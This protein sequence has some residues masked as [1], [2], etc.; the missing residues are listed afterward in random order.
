MDTQK[1]DQTPAGNDPIIVKNRPA[2]GLMERELTVCGSRTTLRLEPAIWASLEDMAG[3]DEHAIDDLC[4]AISMSRPTEGNLS[5]SIRQ[6]VLGF[7]RRS[8]NLTVVHSRHS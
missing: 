6:F 3:A 2:D 4:T 5:N 1:P 8:P 7:N